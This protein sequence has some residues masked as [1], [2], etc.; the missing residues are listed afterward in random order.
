MRHTTQANINRLFG[1]DTQ[2]DAGSGSP[3]RKDKPMRVP[4]V[5][6]CVKFLT[7]FERD[8]HTIAL[9]SRFGWQIERYNRAHK[10]A[11]DE[12]HGWRVNVE[13]RYQ[14]ELDTLRTLRSTPGSHAAG[15][16]RQGL[17]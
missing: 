16:G 1:V 5:G 14:A 3:D 17:P 8:T 6:E 2:V 12:R 7:L 4:S 10:H 13:E 11:A 15:K 9:G